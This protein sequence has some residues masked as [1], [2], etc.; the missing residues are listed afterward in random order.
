MMARGSS[1]RGLSSVTPPRQQTLQQL[2]PSVDVCL[3]QIATTAK[4]APQL[5]RTV[6]ARR[7]K[8]FSSASGVCA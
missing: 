6:Q 8:A 3:Y 4:D 1:V 2:R 5:A 7:R